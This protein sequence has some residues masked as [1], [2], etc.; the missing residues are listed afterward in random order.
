MINLL[1]PDRKKQI[2]AGQTNVLLLRYCI[3]SV[4]LALLLLM[5]IVGVYIIMNNSQKNAEQSI[6]KVTQDSLAYQGSK[7]EAEEFKKNLATAKA[8]LDKDIKY[9]Q[10]AIKIAQTIP[11]GIVLESLSLDTESFGQPMVLNAAAHNYGDSLR[12][13][14]AFEESPM[15]SDA[16][17]QSVA[18]DS[19]R[20]PPVS[21]IISVII[22]QEILKNE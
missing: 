22:N 14:S 12:L 17:I 21:I 11:S 13:K 4:I 1:P 7:R 18:S 3:F 9:S 20:K 2:I 15:F 8:I 6:E 5:L 16:H 10:I 19:E